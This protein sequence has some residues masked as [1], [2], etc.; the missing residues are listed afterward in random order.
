MCAETRAPQHQRLSW[1]PAAWRLGRRMAR[2]P[3]AWSLGLSALLLLA[4]ALWVWQWQLGQQVAA[5]VAADAAQAQA[6][7]QAAAADA[8]RVAQ[9]LA[10]RWQAVPVAPSA[11]AVSAHGLV[12]AR[13]VG[14]R[15]LKVQ[16]R[17]RQPL[18]GQPAITQQVLQWELL[19]PYAELKQWLSEMLARHDTLALNQLSLD[20]AAGAAQGGVQASVELGLLGRRP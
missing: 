7:Q 13:A 6:R 14:L 17:E 10:Q 12:A 9:A 15:V 18:P 8:A 19:G 1:A 3:A 4:W 11:D 5:Q 2:Q 20:L 16:T